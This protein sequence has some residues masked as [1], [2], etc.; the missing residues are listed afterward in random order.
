MHWFG[1][2]MICA[3][4]VAAADAASKRM[5]KG[6]AT[7][8]LAIVRFGLPALLL[9]PLLVVVRPTLPRAEF[10]YWVLPAIP[11]EILA[12][13]LYIRALRGSPLYLCLPMLALTPLSTSLVG[14]LLLGESLT[15]GGLAG[16]GMLVVGAYALNIEQ[17]RVAEPVTWFAPFGAIARSHGARAMLAVAAIWSVTAVLSKGAMAHMPAM[18]FAPLYVGLVGIAN[19]LF[20]G[21]R[22]PGAWRRLREAP[23]PVLLVAG[24]LATSYLAHYAAL[25]QV[26]TAYMIAVKRTSILFGI[27]WGALLFGER[28]PW[29]HLAAGGIM[30]AGLALLA[31]RG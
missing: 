14:Y 28:R 27:L 8:E 26:E 13:A 23:L 6:Y 2:A 22:T 18:G 9:L 29:Q 16:I 5:F 10:W 19:L 17:A 20:F 1:L 30:F 12:E 24:L 31:L 3:A 11:L 25:A 15:A 4:S 21:T 7:G